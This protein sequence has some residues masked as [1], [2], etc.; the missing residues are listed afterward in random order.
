MAHACTLSAPAFALT[1][2]DTVAKWGLLGRWSPDCKKPPADAHIY[3]TFAEAKSVA[4]RVVIGSEGGLFAGTDQLL[5]PLVRND[6][7]IQFERSTGAGPGMVNVYANNSEQKIRLI[8]S[9]RVGTPSYGVQD[10]KFTSQ[11]RV[12]ETVWL[13]R[14]ERAGS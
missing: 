9:Y 5:H 1:D 8:E 11:G 7:M 6:G 4:G 3:L 2:L 14:C 10:G 13:S 12:I